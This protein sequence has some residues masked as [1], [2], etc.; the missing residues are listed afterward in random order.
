VNRRELVAAAISLVVVLNGSAMAADAQ[1]SNT[2]A[3]AVGQKWTVKN[4]GM[5]IVVGRIDPF[6]GGKTA[7]SISVFDVPCPPGTGCTTTTIG[8]APF[9][10]DALAKSVDKLIGT[11]VPTADQFE[12][13]YTNWQQAKGGIFTV[14]VSELPNL[15]TTTIQSGQ[16]RRD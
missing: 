15:L 12:N 8:H 16:R 3:F 4:S 6:A 7:I 10:R 2:P 1:S 13:G 14:P 11:S 5:T 9:D